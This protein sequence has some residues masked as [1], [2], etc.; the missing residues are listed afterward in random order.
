MR[1]LPSVRCLVRTI[2]HASLY[3]FLSRS[4]SPGSL[5]ATLP[6]APAPFAVIHSDI[7]WRERVAVTTVVRNLDGGNLAS[8]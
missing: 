4:K 7:F 8:L 2:A 6:T 1:R 3:L 5:A